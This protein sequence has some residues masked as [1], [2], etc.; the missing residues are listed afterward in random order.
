MQA[1]DDLRLAIHQRVFGDVETERLKTGAGDP[2]ILHQKALAAADIKHPV[3]RLEP[4]MRD[5][6]LGDI[7]PPPRV[8]GVAAI[9]G[10]PRPVEI[11]SPVLA[12]D[13]NVLL[14]LRRVA[15]FDIALR[16]RI[17][18][19]KI[20]FGHTN[21][22]A[23]LSTR[24]D[25]GPASDRRADVADPRAPWLHPQPRRIAT[26]GPAPWVSMPSS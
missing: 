10:V 6:V 26:C 9:A 1:A 20:D 14:A 19:Q 22:F 13:G 8:I 11:L 25:N 3:A 5:H 23:D 12:G 7:R 17:S 4:E 16:S 21:A 18:A 24:V 15:L 2:Q